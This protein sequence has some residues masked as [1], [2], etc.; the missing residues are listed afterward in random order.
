MSLS[1]DRQ[2]VIAVFGGNSVGDDVLVSARR[3]ARVL[4]ARDVI[5]LTGGVPPPKIS[6]VKGAVLNEVQANGAKWIGIHNCSH[7]GRYGPLTERQGL[8]IV[9]HPLMGEQRNF[10]EALLSD[11]AVVLP[12]GS[13]AIS[14]AVSML[15]LRK[16]VLLAG[17][18]RHWDEHCR[19]LYDLFLT[20]HTDATSAAELVKRSEG[21]LGL[22]ALRGQAW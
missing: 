20:K 19:S 6:Q 9:V 11:A 13:G 3:F 7:R 17:T 15:C 18:G 1:S 4:V 22:T 21:P 14:E 16:P 10:L 5:V 8:G 2:K 12:G